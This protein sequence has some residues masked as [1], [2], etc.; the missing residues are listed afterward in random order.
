MDPCGAPKKTKQ[1]KLK[2]VIAILTLS[3]FS[4]EVYLCIASDLRLKF[5]KL[6]TL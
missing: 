6:S 2:D 3:I 5:S 4:A 1:K